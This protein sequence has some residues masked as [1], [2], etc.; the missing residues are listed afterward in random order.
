MAI[1]CEYINL[2]I[3]ISKIDS[4]Y[5]GGFTKFKEDNAIGFNMGVLWHDDFLFRE[6]AMNLS[7]LEFRIKK[8]ESLGLIGLSNL[9]GKQ[10]WI[11]FCV[12]E[13]MFDGDD[14]NCDW[15]SYDSKTRCA[16]MKDKP[17]GKIA[18]REK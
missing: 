4:V 18:F 2:I 10:K 6:G 14:T 1:Y 15:L 8:W 7:S 9:N 5:I 11:D 3:P 13:S 16:Y 17:F 12:F